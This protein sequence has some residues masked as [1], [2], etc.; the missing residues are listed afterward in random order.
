M[1]NQKFE[2]PIDGKSA[3][4]PAGGFG[5]KFKTAVTLGA[6]VATL[7]GAACA[8]EKGGLTNEDIENDPDVAK[9]NRAFA[10]V[11]Q[12]DDVLLASYFKHINSGNFPAHMEREILARAKDIA[13]KKGFR[14]VEGTD[15]GVTAV[16]TVPA[17]ITIDGRP[18]PVGPSDYTPRELQIV[19][20]IQSAR[21][22]LGGQAV[23]KKGVSQT[24]SSPIKNSI[25]VAP[26]LKDF[27]DDDNKPEKRKSKSDF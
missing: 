26:D 23:E 6:T 2:S 20:G 14:I 8:P 13:S 4:K 12:T 9:L 22:S 1:E 7:A 3:E 5:N 17:E 10:E 16:G 27:F 19:R 15:I 24:G 18:V 11:E 21:E 25:Y